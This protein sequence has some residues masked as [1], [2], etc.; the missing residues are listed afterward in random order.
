[1]NKTTRNQHYIFESLYMNTVCINIG[2]D[3][4]TVRI[5]AKY[6]L[7]NSLYQ[8]SLTCFLFVFL[9]KGWNF[10]CI[11]NYNDSESFPLFTVAILL[12]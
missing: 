11:H 9:T 2:Q 12:S 1:M 10:T 8:C 4:A 7:M 3:Q 6:V 5:T